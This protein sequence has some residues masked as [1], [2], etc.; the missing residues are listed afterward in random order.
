MRAHEV[1][2]GDI[3]PDGRRVLKVS[4]TER[5]LYIYVPGE[6]SRPK[7]LRY[8]PDTIMPG[9]DERHPSR[10]TQH[11]WTKYRSSTAGWTSTSKND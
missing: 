2:A 11:P 10:Y 5:C 3:L 1:Q 4:R 7:R 9:P 6:G 8:A